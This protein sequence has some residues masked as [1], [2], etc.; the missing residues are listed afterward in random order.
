MV[1]KNPSNGQPHLQIL[2]CCVLALRTRDPQT[3]KTTTIDDLDEVRQICHGF[4]IKVYHPENVYA[5]RW[6]KGD[7]VIFHNRGVMHSIT[8]QLAQRP[9]R[10]LLW[11][12]NM[13]SSA[14]PEPYRS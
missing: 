3:G 7:L 11:Q 6:K 13:A 4:Q 5:H 2:G 9:E 14:E 10:R 1:W 8:G 12:C